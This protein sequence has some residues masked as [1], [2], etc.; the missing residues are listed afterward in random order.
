MKSI[1]YLFL[2]F[3]F[4]CTSTSQENINLSRENISYSERDTETDWIRVKLN[5][6]NKWG[7]IN[8]DSVIVIPF[9][10][11]FLNPFKDGLAYAKNNGK[12]FFL[13]KKNL[14]LEG[15]FD[16]VDIF[17]EE[18]AAAKRNKKWGFI[19]I[20]GEF[21]ISP[22]YYKVEYFR[23][24]GLCAVQ[25]NGKSGFI[26]KN[27]QEII[28]II[29]DDVNQQMIDKNVIAE[30]SG[31]FAV[32]NSNGKQLSGFVYD[33]I[34]RTDIIDFSK[35]I[36]TRGASTYFENGAALVERDGKFEFINLKAQPAFLNNK[37]DSASTFNTFNNAIVKRNGKYGIINSDGAFKVPLEYDFINYFDD[38]HDFSEY[39]NAK[40]GKVYSIFNRNLKKIGES[41]KPVYY[42]FSSDTSVLIFKD[43]KNK[44]GMINSDGHI[45]IP[46][47]FD[48]ISTIGGT[49]F[50]K[51]SKHQKFGI[52]DQKGQV[53]IPIQYKEL[54]S[55]YEKFDDEE[56]RKKN[57]FVG[58]NKIIN[59][60]NKVWIDGYDSIMS[61]F[62]N[63]N[64]LIVSKNKKF[65]IINVDKHV[66]LPLE[67]DAI[68]NWTEDGLRH[69]KFIVKNGKTGLIDE[70]SFKITIPPIYDKFRYL[71]GLIFAKKE[72]KAGI[73]NEEGQVLC[74][75]IYDEIYPNVS[76]FYGFSNKESRIY[77]KKN[78]AYFQINP[79]GKVLKSNLTKKFVIDNSEIPIV[80]K[81][82]VPESSLP[83]RL[84]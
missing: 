50:L 14:K 62:N 33:K 17:S 63:H 81:R 10:Y 23:P 38:N 79:K 65:G 52:I 71:N 47:E 39:Y 60:N 66:I 40:K 56:L 83:V 76:D 55:L 70:E 51:V 30:K 54:Y 9:D 20:E 18:L 8:R 48:E 78:N 27:G 72:N 57:L 43:L 68:S 4:S 49:R 46:F 73:I 41:F 67:Y 61:V 74:D 53:K 44:Y 77:A 24:N 6:P 7:Y 21:V 45:L 25:K 59:V 64:F 69:S 37:F 42:D 12:E 11:D 82:E 16:A 32:F 28:P 5:H 75:F 3:I 58:D 13:T 2:F 36:F 22:K 80:N 26:N 35:D 34:H 29:F 31:K 84:K 1:P 15:D 19:N